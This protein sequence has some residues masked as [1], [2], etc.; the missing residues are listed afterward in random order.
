MIRYVN[1][2]GTQCNGPRWRMR[3]MV[4]FQRNV[5]GSKFSVSEADNRT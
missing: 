2:V 5:N 1:I 4:N 3:S